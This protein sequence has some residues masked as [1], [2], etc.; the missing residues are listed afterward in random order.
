MSENRVRLDRLEAG[1]TFEYMS[2]LYL[3]TNEVIDE[4]ITCVDLVTGKISWF[5]KEALVYRCE[6]R[7][8]VE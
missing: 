7:F 4:T 2:N 5:A 6:A 3:R 1:D 8:T